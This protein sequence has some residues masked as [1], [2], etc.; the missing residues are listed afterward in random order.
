[1][2][3]DEKGELNYYIVGYTWRTKIISSCSSGLLEH[4]NYNLDQQS[5]HKVAYL[6][7]SQLLNAELLTLWMWELDADTGDLEG[8]QGFENK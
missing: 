2:E 7:R 1:M 4:W 3:E 8:L 6:F 5:V